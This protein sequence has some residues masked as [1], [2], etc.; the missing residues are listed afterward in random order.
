MKT[1]LFDT[2]IFDKL[3]NDTDACT[4]LQKLSKQRAVRMIISVAVHDELAGSPHLALLEKLP[5]EVV[6]NATSVV[7]IMRAGDY[8]GDADHY[9][10]HKGESGKEND[11]LVA[12][13]AEFHAD[14]LV[15]DDRRLAHRQR[16][17]AKTDLAIVA[18]LNDVL[19]NPR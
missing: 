4:L 10:N 19:G 13:V 8:L 5:I 6:G 15:S 3:A 16:Q 18:A 14:W 12:A 2:N 11:A 17:T 7:G 1:I 9:F